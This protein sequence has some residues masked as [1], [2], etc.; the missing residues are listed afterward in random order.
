MY[1]RKSDNGSFGL[2]WLFIFWLWNQKE[3]DWNR[4]GQIWDFEQMKCQRVKF[5]KNDV[6]KAS[7]RFS[8]VMQSGYLIAFSDPVSLLNDFY[9]RPCDFIQSYDIA[10]HVWKLK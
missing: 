7:D 4:S 1:W 6:S 8:W 10:L 9:K 3:S 2:G 5:C